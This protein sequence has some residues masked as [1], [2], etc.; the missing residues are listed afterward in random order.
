MPPCRGAMP[1]LLEGVNRHDHEVV[2]CD[3]LKA[4][5]WVG[6]TDHL[7]FGEFRRGLTSD[8]I[9]V[10]EHSWAATSSR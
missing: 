2:L 1:F 6:H 4:C 8:R 5:Q 9:D 10:G 3:V 7:I